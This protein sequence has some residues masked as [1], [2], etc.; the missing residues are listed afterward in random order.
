MIVKRSLSI[1]SVVSFSLFFSNIFSSERTYYYTSQLSL[2]LIKDGAHAFLSHAQKESEK[3][4]ESAIKAAVS[5]APKNNMNAAA[6][7]NNLKNVTDEKIKRVEYQLEHNHTV[8]RDD[9]INGIVYIGV[10]IG[11]SALVYAAY[12]KWLKPGHDEY[13]R[14]EE[15]TKKMGVGVSINWFNRTINGYTHKNISLT[16]EQINTVNAN[17]KTLADLYNKNSNIFGWIGAGALV[18]LTALG[19][20]AKKI[21]SSFYPNAENAYLDKYKLVSQLIEKQQKESH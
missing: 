9:L 2:S 18:P 1:I 20:G 17:L 10:G 6:L 4:I 5:L 11:L 19:V 15:A 8:N 7:L 16:R 3:E 21:I 12:N 14:I 13:N